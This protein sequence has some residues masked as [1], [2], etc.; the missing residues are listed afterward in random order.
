MIKVSVVIPSLYKVDG[1][2]LKLAVQSLRETTDWQI[3]VVTNGDTDGEP[4]PEIANTAR[5]LHTSDQGQ[6]NAVNIG[7]AAVPPD[8]DYIFVSNADMYYAPGW[9]D[10]LRFDELC[11]S[12]NLL[13]PVNNAG[14]APPFMK[15]DG[16][17]TLEEFD[18][19]KVDEEVAK[20]GENGAVVPEVGFNLPFFIR[21]DVWDT[22]GG[23]D[24]VYDPWGSN[25]DTDFQTKV[26]LAG[27]TP[28]R[29]LDMLVYHFSNKSGTFDGTHQDAWQNNWDYY[30][31][32]WGFNRD[33]TKADTWYCKNMI[34]YDKLKYKPEWEGKYAKN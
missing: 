9:N 1:D 33:D 26:E 10:N 28:K 15:V 6:C 13:E 18:K 12:P 14:S 31:E 16:G 22:I 29:Y 17:L 7:A 19:V 20:N 3:T 11:F 25:S 5:R 4:I 24:L 23:Y 21:K 2:Y 32:K 27:V 8:T 30:T 34:D